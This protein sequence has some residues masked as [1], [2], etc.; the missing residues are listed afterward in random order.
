[1]H[2]KELEERIGVNSGFREEKWD[3]DRLGSEK[4][5]IGSNAAMNADG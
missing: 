3:A 5:G 2:W 4:S 1:M